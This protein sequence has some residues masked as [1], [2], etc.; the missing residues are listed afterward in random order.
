MVYISLINNLHYKYAK[1]ALERNNNLVI[2]KP[3]T[4][5]F[6]HTKKLVELA[7]QKRLLLCELTIFDQHKIFKNINK[8]FGGFK[9]IEHIHTTFNVPL[10]NKNNYLEK[11]QKGANQDMGPYA[12]AFD[13][14]FFNHIKRKKIYLK[15]IKKKKLITGF[16]LSIISKKKTYFGDFSVQKPY[17]SKMI[18]YSKN[19]SA[20]ID[21]KA[22][23][24]PTDK[25]IKLK[26]KNNLYNFNLN[27]KD[28]YIERFFKNLIMGKHNKSYY[29][30][31]INT[32]NLFR[33]KYKLIN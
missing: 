25:K 24:L 28:D 26:I 13:R 29:Y 23:A 16:S 1:L 3:I 15:K 10:Y 31:Q 11:I 4:T 20:E 5:K 9:K 32:D 30:D 22:F 17:Q 18:F 27:L 6:S 12:A 14:I 8:V 19:K 2:D 33:K 21:F 7:K